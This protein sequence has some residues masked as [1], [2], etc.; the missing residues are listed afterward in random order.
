MW[1]IELVF[2]LVL[3]I[4]YVEVRISRSISESPLE[5]EITR[6]DCTLPPCIHAH[7]TEGQPAR[8]F[9][10]ISVSWIWKYPCLNLPYVRVLRASNQK[11][12][13]VRTVL[14]QS[15]RLF[16]E[17]GIFWNEEQI[18]KRIKEES[19]WLSGHDILSKHLC[20]ILTASHSRSDL[21]A[22]SLHSSLAYYMALKHFIS[23][24][25]IFWYDCANV[26]GD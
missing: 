9:W 25:R 13:D 18:K 7:A 4:W 22:L 16:S 2:S 15:S 21:P 14:T 20:D 17:A 23:D 8:Q 26:Q 12:S 3:Q 5:F 1:L 6:V 19:V 11:N 10:S 24:Q